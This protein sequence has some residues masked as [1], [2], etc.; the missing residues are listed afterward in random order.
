M[1][2]VFF[3]IDTQNDFMLPA[4]ALYVPGAERLL[5]AIARLNRWAGEKGIPLF[6]TTDAHEESDAEFREWPAHC[7]AGTLGQQKPAE[8]L[9]ERHVSLPSHPAPAVPAAQTLVEKQQLDCFSNAN[10]AEFLRRLDAERYVVYG[11]VTEYCVRFAAE[12]LLET[13][14]RVDIVTDAIA[15]LS[16]RDSSSALAALTASGARL[17]TLSEVTG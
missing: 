5:P 14:K 8:T 11:V 10:L 2:M 7:V 17:T 6:S 9:L 4:G 16:E 12:G 15:A 1:K 3:D 13:G